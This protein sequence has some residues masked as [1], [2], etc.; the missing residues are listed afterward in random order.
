MAALVW[1][2]REKKIT[3]IP[4]FLKVPNLMFVVK[5]SSKKKYQNGP[6]DQLCLVPFSPNHKASFNPEA[7][8]GCQDFYLNQSTH[9]DPDL[10]THH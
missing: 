9:T 2:P 4:T 1:Q 5:S 8:Q 7:E 3:L 6:Q 10:A